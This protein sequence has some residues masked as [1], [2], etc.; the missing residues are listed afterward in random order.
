MIITTKSFVDMNTRVGCKSNILTDK[1][2]EIFKADKLNLARIK[3]IS[4]FIIALSKVQTVGFEKLAVAFEGKA[5]TS[6]SLRRIQRFI[7]R[8]LRLKSIKQKRCSGISN[9]HFV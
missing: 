5:K 2:V 8:H 1:L 7:E 4:L 3:F 9:N 6:F